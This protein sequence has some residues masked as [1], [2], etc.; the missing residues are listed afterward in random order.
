M[1]F[2]I[3]T[4]F[5]PQTG[6]NKDSLACDWSPHSYL[7]NEAVNASKLATEQFIDDIAKSP[8]V[9]DAQLRLLFGVGT[10][11]AFV[12][13]TTG[14]MADIQASVTAQAI[15][16]AT[17]RLA[18]V[19]N[20]DLFV[21]SPFNDP[22]TGPV[23]SVSDIATFNLIMDGLPAFGGGDCPE[24]S[25]TG[26]LKA[27][28][29]VTESTELFLFTDAASKDYTLEPQVIAAALEKNVHINIFK[30][31]S[32][33]DDGLK[34][35]SDSAS[36]RVYGSLAAATGG[37]Y[38]SLPRNNVGS[39]SSLLATLTAANSNPV[40]KIS[41]TLAGGFGPARSADPSNSYSF[42]V[43]TLMTQLS[44]LISGARVTLTYTA[45]S[46]IPAS[47]INTVMLADG[48]HLTI[49]SPPP[50]LWEV[51]IAGT[52]AF[53]LDIS[54]ISPLNFPVFDFVESRGRPGHTGYFP[55]SGPPPYNADIAVIARLFG[56]FSS[57][58][59]FC[60]RLDGSIISTLTLTPGS[61][62]VG[63]PD[64]DSFFGVLRLTNEPF[65]VYASGVDGS[66]QSFQRLLATVITPVFSNATYRIG[67]LDPLDL[68][69]F[70]TTSGNNSSL[71]SNITTFGPYSNMTMTSLMYSITEM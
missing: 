12:M 41:T 33:C 34:K 16:I 24:M 9:T 69:S 65:Y 52:G 13:D 60:K 47:N 64:K 27:I 53:T 15:Q 42:S 58:E 36:N 50:G 20:V 7:H 44:I 48:E 38:H 61:G 59:F 17:D 5:W 1:E 49:S 43:D 30:F 71:P 32:N 51:T 66:G 23:Q 31:D 56:S 26:I 10:T 18:T 35:R 14:S 55:I 54:G 4:A 11:F 29:Q 3:G 68:G 45:P 25:M 63:F 70:I 28:A 39:I 46:A 67:T 57:A 2:I 8:G 21:I 40:L 62:E 22:A 6:I 37:S 19:D